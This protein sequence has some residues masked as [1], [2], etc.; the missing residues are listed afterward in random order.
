M[1]GVPGELSTL[2]GARVN[3][4]GTITSLVDL[5]LEFQQD[6]TLTLNEDTLTTALADHL[7]EVKTLFV[8]KTDATGRATVAGVGTLLTDRLTDM[9]R[10]TGRIATEKQATQTQIDRLDANITTTKARLDRRYDTLARQ[11]AALDM[12]AAKLQS[13]GDFLSGFITSLDSAKQ[14]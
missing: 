10:A 7:D 9:T 14:S 13:Q 1:Q 12:Y 3:T 4:G 8:G 11:F 2:L 5:G 6:G